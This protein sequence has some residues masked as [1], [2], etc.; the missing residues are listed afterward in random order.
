MTA[1]I[2][3]IALAFIAGRPNFSPTPQAAAIAAVYPAKSGVRIERMNVVGRYATVLMQGA[4]VESQPE[5]VPILVERFSFGWQ[6][7]ESLDFM[8]RL[9]AHD[10]GPRTEELLMRGM[11][12]PQDDRPCGFVGKDTGPELQVEALRRSSTGP[13][14]P[15]I[16]VAG[17]YAIRDWYGAGGG[18]TLFQ[19]IRGQWKVLSGGGGALGVEQLR[20]HGVPQG[21]WCALHV[22]GAPHC[23]NR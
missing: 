15:D 16:V 23:H 11:P 3:A 21:D 8:C 1:L 14:T 6:A 18:Q 19:L 5:R 7:L 12:A 4:M 2:A 20:E 17:N 10:L 9:T 13:L 22:V